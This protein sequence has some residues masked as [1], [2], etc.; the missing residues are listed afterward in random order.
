[1]GHVRAGQDGGVVGGLVLEPHGC[2]LDGRA[3]AGQHAGGEAADGERGGGH[4]HG[5]RGPLLGLV[6]LAGLLGGLRRHL[7]ILAGRVAQAVEHPSGH[8][9]H[10]RADQHGADDQHG[11]QPRHAV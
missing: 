9:Q 6:G 5:K 3:D 7:G 10:G 4:D 11:R 1:M 8:P 2:R